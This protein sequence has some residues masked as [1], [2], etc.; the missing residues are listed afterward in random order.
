VTTHTPLDRT[1]E[2]SPLESQPQAQQAKT[3]GERGATLTPTSAPEKNLRGRAK[4]GA[5]GKFVSSDASAGHDRPPDTLNSLAEADRRKNFRFIRRVRDDEKAPLPI[6]FR[7]AELLAMHSDGKPSA[8]ERA[9]PVTAGSASPRTN[10]DSSPLEGMSPEAAH[11]WL[12]RHPEAPPELYQRTVER[13]EAASAE[14]DRAI[15]AEAAPPSPAAPP[16]EAAQPSA[17][18]APSGEPADAPATP[19]QA[20]AP[21][22][23]TPTEPP[24]RPMPPQ[25]AKIFGT[26]CYDGCDPVA[27]RRRA[28]AQFVKAQRQEAQLEREMG[29]AARAD[30]LLAE[31][32]DLGLTE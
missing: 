30:A 20:E 27:L 14:R 19:T 3:R 13:L 22:P 9:A 10:T 26:L 11:A 18:P 29:R 15:E 17:A 25:V 16:V 5:D 31:L 6:R 12:I 4:R 7:A 28:E 32:R 8:A 1:P 23:L 24:M 2:L 21:A